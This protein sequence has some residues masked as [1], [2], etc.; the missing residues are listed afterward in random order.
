MA[1]VNVTYVGTHDDP[2]TSIQAFGQTFE[3]GKVV[4]IDDS[5]PNFAK[6]SNNPTF[7]VEK[8]AA[9]AA[10]LS[11]KE[12]KELERLRTELNKVNVAYDE[13]ESADELQRKLDEANA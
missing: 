5:D 1:K 2:T 10:R 11:A 8:E 9:P 13:T 12:V 6:L 3:K 4:S 7:A